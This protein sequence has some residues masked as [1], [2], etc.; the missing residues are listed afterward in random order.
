MKRRAQLPG[1][2]EQAH[3]FADTLSRQLSS[4]PRGVLRPTMALN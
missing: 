2:G 3:R 4:T 1:G